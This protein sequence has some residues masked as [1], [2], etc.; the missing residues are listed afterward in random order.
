MKAGRK[1]KDRASGISNTGGSI[2]EVHLVVNP[3]QPVSLRAPK[4]AATSSRMSRTLKDPASTAAM[5]AAGT[6]RPSGGGQLARPDERTA[7]GLQP[8]LSKEAGAQ[9]VDA[10]ESSVQ[11]KRDLI[12][13]RQDAQTGRDGATTNRRSAGQNEQSNSKSN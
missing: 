8:L 3:A 12:S 13:A 11:T 2:K 6:L 10:L 9:A 1:G 7:G 4:M 5:R